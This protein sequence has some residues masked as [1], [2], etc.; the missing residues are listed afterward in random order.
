MTETGDVEEW[1][2]IRA[3]DSTDPDAVRAAWD[4]LDPLATLF[5]VGS[6]SGTTTET[7]AFQADAWA[8]IH[9]ALRSHGARTEGGLDLVRAEASTWREGHGTVGI[10]RHPRTTPAGSIDVRSPAYLTAF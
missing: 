1:L 8:R 10:I 4:G 2:T 3:L 7:L 6:K 9:E 5:V